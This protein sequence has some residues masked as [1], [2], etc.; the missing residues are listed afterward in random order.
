VD[1]ILYDDRALAEAEALVEG[2]TYE[3]VADLRAR[4]W[5]GGLRAAFRGGSL[6]DIA[7]RMVAI[8][9]GGLERRGLVDGQAAKTSACTWRACASWWVRAAAGRRAP[10][11]FDREPDPFKA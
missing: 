6:I 7:Q 11:G 2:W 1:R 5:Q 8:A 9:D 10:R 3:E 4:V